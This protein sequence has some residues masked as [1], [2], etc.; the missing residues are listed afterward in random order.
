MPCEDGIAPPIADAEDISEGGVVCDEKETSK[1]RTWLHGVAI[2]ANGKGVLITGASGIGKTTAA[3][4]V[5]KP[6]YFWIADDLAVVGKERDG[7]LTMTGHR[8]IR[9]YF[10]TDQTGVTEIIRILPETQIKRKTELNAVID[11][12]RNDRDD[13]C[14]ENG[15]KQILLTPLPCLQIF[16]PRK[17]YLDKS[18][19]TEALDIFKRSG[20]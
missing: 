10:H 16:I 14:Y 11:V 13:I 5:M 2:E 18:L 12:L 15:E 6:G 17:G 1:K 7:V 9:K 19:L 4:H 8:K 3:I 20:Q